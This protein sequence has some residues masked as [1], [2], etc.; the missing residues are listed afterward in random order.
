LESS[1]GFARNLGERESFSDAEL[2][3]PHIPSGSR[4]CS[5]ITL[6]KSAQVLDILLTLFLFSLIYNLID[7]YYNSQDTFGNTPNIF[8]PHSITT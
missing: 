6:E 7:M 8:G 1:F 4:A 2:V 5:Q 3:L